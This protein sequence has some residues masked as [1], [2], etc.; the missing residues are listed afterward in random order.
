[1]AGASDKTKA[2]ETAE[3]EPTLVEKIQAEVNLRSQGRPDIAEQIATAHILHFIYDHYSLPDDEL[4]ELLSAEGV[5]LDDNGIE[6]AK[7][8]LKVA[9]ESN[10]MADVRHGPS[11]THNQGPARRETTRVRAES[12]HLHGQAPDKVPSNITKI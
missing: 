8:Y 1:M 4:R 7:N 6:A 10:I 9:G 2:N 5:E 11:A 12:V 3:K